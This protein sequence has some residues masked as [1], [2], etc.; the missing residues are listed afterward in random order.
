MHHF[1]KMLFVAAAL[2]LLTGCSKVNKENYDKLKMGMEYT[3]V[4]TILGKPTNCT[5]SMGTRVCIWGSET[6][7]IK[8]TFLG[9]KTAF[10]SNDGLQ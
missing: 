9:D 8:V 3:E 1:I 10:F 5:E 7:H 6:K 2:L 4:T